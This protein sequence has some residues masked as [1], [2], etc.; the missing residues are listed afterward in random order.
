[1][2]IDA[3]GSL[4]ESALL[5]LALSASVVEAPHANTSLI[6]VTGESNA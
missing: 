4:R 5:W 1:V 3:G 6:I 2:V